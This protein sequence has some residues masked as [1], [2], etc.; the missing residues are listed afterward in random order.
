NTSD[1]LEEL[2]LVQKYVVD[3]L[4]MIKQWDGLD[5]TTQAQV[6]IERQSETTTRLIQGR[7]LLLPNLRILR[8]LISWLYLNRVTC[9]LLYASTAL[10]KITLGDTDE[11]TSS[12]LCRSLLECRPNLKSVQS[13]NL[14]ADIASTDGF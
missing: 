14:L 5:V 11:E 6:E 9:S 7:P 3:T 8:L 13:L 4:C 12:Q 1:S 2:E 10:D